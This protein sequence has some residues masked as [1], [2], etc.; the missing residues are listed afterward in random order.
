MLNERT[1]RNKVYQ[2]EI[3]DVQKRKSKLLNNKNNDRKEDP[4]KRLGRV[5]NRFSQV[6]DAAPSDK[7]PTNSRAGVSRKSKGTSAKDIL[8]RRRNEIG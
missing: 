2:S 5:F 4:A 1:S 6:K 7:S 3:V 8:A